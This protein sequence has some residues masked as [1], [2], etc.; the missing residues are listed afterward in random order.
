MFTPRPIAEEAFYIS[1]KAAADT[2]HAEVKMVRAE[3][4]LLTEGNS[5]LRE[6]ISCLEAISTIR[7]DGCNPD[8][9]QLFELKLVSTDI[10]GKG[11]EDA[12]EVL[13][14][15]GALE[16]CA[17]NVQPGSDITPATLLEIHSR[18]RYG[19]G[20]KESGVSFRKSEF[21]KPTNEEYLHYAPSHPADIESLVEDLCV[22]INK[23]IYSPITQAALAHFQ[24]EGIKPFKSEMD[25]TGRAMC[26]AVFFRRGFMLGTI[27]PISLLP[28]LYIKTHAQKL[29]PYDTGGNID[30]NLARI[31]AMNQW[32]SFC[33][34]SAKLAAQ[35]VDLFGS[36]VEKLNR[37]WREQT[38]RLSKG[39]VAEAMLSVI[40]SNPVL[41]VASAIEIT[42]YSF[43]AVNDAL[44]RMVQAGILSVSQEPGYKM[45]VFRANDVLES[46]EKNLDKLMTQDPIP[47]N[48][49]TYS[50]LSSCFF[51]N[52][53][54][55]EAEGKPKNSPSCEGS[56]CPF[57]QK[58]R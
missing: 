40:Q 35:S 22:F 47:R 18:C 31:Q 10:A 14:Y 9:K 53:P 29:M 19:V 46:M 33:A 56:E 52:C 12:L 2:S 3:S 17:Q 55:V 54:H 38:G 49:F 43:S 8:P 24:F 45:R 57:R 11:C 58:T 21:L 44:N 27:T 37:K 34:Y 50:D 28:A 26:H 20:R 23:E 13:R 15:K 4:V 41:T 39:S 30:E 6:I 32:I 42:G 1:G 36:M 48:S 5:A 25:R 16:W 51:I 7:I